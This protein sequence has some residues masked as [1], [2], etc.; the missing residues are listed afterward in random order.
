MKVSVTGAS[1]FLGSAVLKILKSYGIDAIGFTVNDKPGLKKLR[2]YHDVPEGDCLIHLAENNNRRVVNALGAEYRNNAVYTCHSLTQGR[3]SKVIYASSALLY[4]DK[5]SL[6]RL[7]TD[8]VTSHDTYSETKLACEELVLK[9]KNNWVARISNLYGS[10]MS[11]NTV[12]S[13]ILNQ[14]HYRNSVEVR[15]TT[16]IRDFLW[17]E[18]AAYA[19]VKMVLSSNLGEIV[20][21]GSGRGTSIRALVKSILSAASQVDRP[22]AKMAVNT[23]KPSVLVLNVT[24]A[25]KVLDWTPTLTIDQ[26]TKKLV[27]E[28][29]NLESK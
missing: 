28:F 24:K 25:K 27:D 7:E 6:P 17:C 23:N 20:N 3:F 29:L 16:P 14:L 21:V 5:V 10:G 15:D 11:E 26:G 9:S 1:G 19:I 4:G 2:S 8:A 18:D 12:F 13:E 22:V